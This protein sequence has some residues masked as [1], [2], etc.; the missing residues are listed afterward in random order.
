[1]IWSSMGLE[2][3]HDENNETCVREYL[4]APMTVNLSARRQP[5]EGFSNF[6]WPSCRRFF[7]SIVL[8]WVCQDYVESQCGCRKCYLNSTANT[9]AVFVA[10]TS[11]VAEA[12]AAPAAAYAGSMLLSAL[13]RIARI[14]WSIQMM[15]QQ[16][17]SHLTNQQARSSF[18]KE[19]RGFI[20]MQ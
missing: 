12:A 4:R 8:E 11:H 3:Y 1:M 5:A 13:L 7:G 9:S 10:K 18:W 20:L 15:R 16:L 19:S 14:S 6:S 17:R 2:V